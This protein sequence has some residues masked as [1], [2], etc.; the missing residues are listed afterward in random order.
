MIKLR[1]LPRPTVLREERDL[2]RV[3]GGDGF[4]IGDILFWQG[5]IYPGGEF[6]IVP[7]GNRAAW[8]WTPDG[9]T[10]TLE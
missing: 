9:W 3:K 2:C 6:T 1:K 10:F 4:V 8:V 5:G 7:T